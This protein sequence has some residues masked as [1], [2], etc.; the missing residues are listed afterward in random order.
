MRRILTIFCI[1]FLL[2]SGATLAQKLY[3]IDQGSIQLSGSASI[4]SQGYEDSDD[5]LTTVQLNTVAGYFIIPNL[6]AGA[7][8]AFV[9]QSL[10]DE[11]STL[12]GIGPKV[13]YYFGDVDSQ[14]YPY[15]TGSFLYFSLSDIYSETAFFIGGGAVFMAAEHIGFTAEAGYQFE[16][17]S[18][19]GGGDSISGHTFGISF[20]IA[21]FLF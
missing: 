3:P 18:P 19:D 4:T 6:L 14:I 13:A 16:N 1:L 2:F 8:L 7:N 9:H 15:L 12:F 10:G 17:Y 21:A 5:D 20:G 11:S